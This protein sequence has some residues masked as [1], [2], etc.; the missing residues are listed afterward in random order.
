MLQIYV[1]VIFQETRQHTQAHVTSCA[2]IHCVPFLWPREEH[3]WQRSWVNDLAG[4]HL[5]W[6]LLL[7]LTAAGVGV[8]V[9]I[10]VLVL[11]PPPNS[12]QHRLPQHLI[13]RW[14]QQ[15]EFH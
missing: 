15:P 9:V 10:V 3:R 14:C 5:L 12:L 6:R 4:Q 7:R 1:C 11:P 13:Q 2:L 8:V